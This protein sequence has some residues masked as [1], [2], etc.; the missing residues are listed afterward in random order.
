MNLR[1]LKFEDYPKYKLFFND[2]SH[3]L[4]AYSLPSVLAWTNDEYQPFG[5]VYKDALILAAEFQ[6]E[7]KYRHLI[8]PLR[9][10][11][12]FSPQEL[13]DIAVT[14]G[15]DEYWFVPEAFLKHQ[16]TSDLKARFHVHRHAELDDYIFLVE[17]LSLLKGNKF[18]KKRNLIN[19]FHRDYVDTGR[20][21]IEPIT[22]NALDDCLE[23]LELWCEER[24]CH[25]GEDMLLACEKQATIN[26][27]LNISLFELTGILLR[28]DGMVSAFGIA[29]PLTRDMAVLQYEKAFSDV[30]GLYQ[31]FDGQ[32]AMRLFNGYTY[33][34]KESDM[35]VEGLKKAKKS[36][37]PVKKM[38]SYRLVLKK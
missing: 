27:L 26:T 24:K 16:G 30:K 3:T 18:S 7:K 23:F 12:D 21:D 31:Y 19:Q 17:D 33:I 28:I 10:G 1:Q 9:P 13:C 2:Q 37:H 35:G 8:L 20:V 25:E 11:H 22:P 34:N 36:Y 29:A 14:S 4:C 6:T 5:A 38:R 15:F 32:C